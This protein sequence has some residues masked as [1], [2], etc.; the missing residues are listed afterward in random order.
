[1]EENLLQNV[2]ILRT[3]IEELYYVCVAA[4]RRDEAFKHREIAQEKIK[5]LSAQLTSLS[6]ELDYLRFISRRLVSYPPR[7]WW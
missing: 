7:G 4:S 3:K 5:A 6:G 1:M 2:E